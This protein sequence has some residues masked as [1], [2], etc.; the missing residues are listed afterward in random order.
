MLSEPPAD[1]HRFSEHNSN[2]HKGCKCHNT[3]GRSRQAAQCPHIF[4]SQI[5]CGNQV[6]EGGTYAGVHS[7]AEIQVCVIV[8]GI[9]FDGDLFFPLRLFSRRP[10]LVPKLFGLL[11]ERGQTFWDKLFRIVIMAGSMWDSGILTKCIVARFDSSL[12]R[13]IADRKLEVRLN[14]RFVMLGEENGEYSLYTNL[15]RD[16]SD[17]E[18]KI[19]EG[20]VDSGGQPMIFLITQTV[21]KI[22]MSN[23]ER[24]LRFQERIRIINAIPGFRVNP[25]M[26]L[27]SQKIYMEIDYDDMAMAEHP[28]EAMQIITSIIKEN[29]IVYIGY[30]PDQYPY[31]IRLFLEFGGNLQGLS[32][33]RTEWNM[34]QAE[35]EQENAGIFGT[36]STFALKLFSSETSNKLILKCTDDD[37]GKVSMGRIINKDKHIWEVGLSS[38]FF[39]DLFSEVFKSYFGAIFFCARVSQGTLATSY[40]IESNLINDFLSGLSRNWN[41]DRRKPH[42]NAIIGINTLVEA[43]DGKHPIIQ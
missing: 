24:H 33:I 18:R 34:T 1:L 17:T 7:G 26:L 8:P 35:I 28:E 14:N 2:D 36:Q 39:Q 10:D 6:T 5:W 13:I 12:P 3:K 9:W 29:E 20:N 11:Q 16:I 22:P 37:P 27:H 31:I 15:G 19:I 23:S 42:H 4:R 40:I 38:S 30:Q 21:L 41:K 25:C 32:E 43:S